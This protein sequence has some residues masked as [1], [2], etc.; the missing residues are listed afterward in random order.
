MYFFFL[1][2]GRILTVWKYWKRIKRWVHGIGFRSGSDPEQ[3]HMPRV[4]WLTPLVRESGLWRG[5]KS[6]YFARF[7]SNLGEQLG[8]SCQICV[9]S[10]GEPSNCSL[11][12]FFWKITC[13]WLFFQEHHRIGH[14]HYQRHLYKKKYQEKM[15]VLMFACLPVYLFICLFIIWRW[16]YKSSMNM[17]L[18]IWFV[19]GFH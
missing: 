10:T 4:Y 7:V 3:A 5:F 11:S 19:P 14:G 9:S 13:I 15:C 8:C 1:S 2:A 12:I 6:L 18:W 16:L 17:L